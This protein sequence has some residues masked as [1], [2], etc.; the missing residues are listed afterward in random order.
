MNS[1]TNLELDVA[2]VLIYRHLN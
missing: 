2:Q 1:E